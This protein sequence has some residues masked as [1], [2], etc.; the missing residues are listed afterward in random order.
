MDGTHAV[1]SARRATSST[2]ALVLRL[3]WF[4]PAHTWFVKG[5]AVIQKGLTN[6]SDRQV[7]IG[8][9][10]GVMSPVIIAVIAIPRR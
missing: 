5:R 3:G 6:T 10:D 2:T 8:R 7:H 1:T 9:V 4:I